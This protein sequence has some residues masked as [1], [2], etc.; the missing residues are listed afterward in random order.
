MGAGASFLPTSSSTRDGS[1]VCRPKNP[2][3]TT[4]NAMPD[5]AL[6]ETLRQLQLSPETIDESV[7]ALNQYARNPTA[8]FVDRDL[9]KLCTSEYIRGALHA[10]ATFLAALESS[11]AEATEQQPS[12][13]ATTGGSTLG[14][15]FG[16][17]YL[18]SAS[19]VNVS[20]TAGTSKGYRVVAEGGDENDDPRNSGTL[21]PAN[22]Q[23]SGGGGGGGAGKL[24][25]MW[26][27]LRRTRSMPSRE[28]AAAVPANRKLDGAPNRPIAAHSQP[29]DNEHDDENKMTV[30]AA[31]SNYDNAD[32]EVVSPRL[33]VRV[34]SSTIGRR[35]SLMAGFGLR[36]PRNAQ[37]RDMSPPRRAPVRTGQ[38]KL[39]HEIGKGSFG[40]VHIG[41]NE[42]SG[43]LIAVKVLSLQNA[44][45]AEPLYRE[46][47]LMRQ[48]THPNIV[49]YLGA[50]VGPVQ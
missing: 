44:D 5:H 19:H 46:I 50:E 8:H 14:S 7:V 35:P 26:G 9:A 12:G 24:S 39:G 42:D 31:D 16:A 29:H 23:A 36:S 32:E 17:N 3:S 38:W 6:R 49:C 18:M 47:E 10:L 2:P 22:L 40:A 27:R 20:P 37:S 43:D 25:T 33:S 15:G 28:H 45:A 34:K 1:V 30:G 13:C 48:L 41:L 4:D 11:G 21:M